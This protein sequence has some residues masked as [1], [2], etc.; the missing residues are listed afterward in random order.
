MGWVKFVAAGVIKLRHSPFSEHYSDS[1]YYV[2]DDI[3]LNEG[4]L[5]NLNVGPLR[6]A[7]IGVEDR[8]LFLLT[9]PHTGR[10]AARNRKCSGCPAPGSMPRIS[11]TF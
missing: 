11:S 5:V 10:C 6:W 3:K 2:P 8:S 4:E 1:F 9:R 7:G